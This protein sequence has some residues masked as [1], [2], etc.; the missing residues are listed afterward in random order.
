MKESLIIESDIHSEDLQDIIA[1][2]PSW[3]LRWGI[4]FILLTVLIILGMSVFIRYPE[5]V[6][7]KIK[8]N[9]TDAPKVISAKVNGSLIKILKKEGEWAEEGSTL[10]YLES[11]ADHD[12][13]I[14]LLNKLQQI[15]QKP[16]ATYNLEE[17]I[18]PNKL[19]LGE[20]QG[21]Y[22]NFYLSYLSYISARDQ[23][24]YQ[25]RKSVINQEVTNVNEQFKKN[26]ESYELQKKQ[27]EL[28]E[29]E[30]EKYKLLAQKKV[31]SPSELQ[32][33]ESLL[34]AKR[35]MIPQMENSLI[36]YE[37]NILSKNK[38][39]AE[40]ENQIEEE[41]KK[42]VQALNSFISEAENWKKQYVMTS[43]VGG[44]L[45][46]GEFLQTNQQVTIGQKLFY[47]NPK[48]EKYYGEV[49]LPQIASAKVK[50]GQKV[51]IKVNGYPY[52]EYGYLHGKVNYISD[53]PI[54]DSVFFTT[55]SLDTTNLNPLIQLKPGLFGNGKIITEDRS[56]FRRI[57]NNLTKNLMVN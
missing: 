47:I 55:I 51:L 50:K 40:I 21:A 24:I 56:I 27:L 44:K 7:T 28:A 22:Q 1:K 6:E 13:I 12:Q 32:Q 42:F 37:G 31:I 17:L 49:L 16:N 8:F 38:E 45:I 15:R 54:Q 36:N 3:L 9:T 33:K 41:H 18:E 29:R 5:T 2:P 20:L 53:I 35:Q 30:Y 26:S 23:G 11:T 25:K 4:T 57:W 39:L 52:E 19:N 48:S 14:I 43:P 34:L 46:Y 10:A